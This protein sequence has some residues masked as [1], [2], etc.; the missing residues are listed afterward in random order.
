MRQSYNGSST[1]SPCS[2]SVVAIV[3]SP[4]SERR[5][6]KLTEHLVSEFSDSLLSIEEQDRL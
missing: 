5:K 4:D 3:T 1:E 2:G 6:Q